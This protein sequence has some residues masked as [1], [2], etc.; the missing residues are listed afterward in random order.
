MD[1]DDRGAPERSDKAVDPAG[2]FIPVAIALIGSDIPEG[3]VNQICKGCM[4]ASNMTEFSLQVY[5]KDPFLLSLFLVS[6]GKRAEILI[7]VPVQELSVQGIVFPPEFFCDRTEP[8]REVPQV[9]L[10]KKGFYIGK[11][12]AFECLFQGTLRVAEEMVPGPA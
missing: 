4:A 10:Y 9:I 3:T 5:N 8:E 7:P 12:R 6:H 2:S 11:R 1:P